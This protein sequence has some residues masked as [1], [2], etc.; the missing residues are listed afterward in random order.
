MCAAVDEDFLN[1][2]V[3]EELEGIFDERGIREG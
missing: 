2:G 3:C 1:T